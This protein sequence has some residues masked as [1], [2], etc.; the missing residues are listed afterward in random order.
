MKTDRGH[1]RKADNNI[2]TG[3]KS[4]SIL[5]ETERSLS[6]LLLLLFPNAGIEISLQSFLASRS[7]SL[8]CD[9]GTLRGVGMG[10]GVTVPEIDVEDLFRNDPIATDPARD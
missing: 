5:K 6:P 8:D 10:I 2:L 9:N 7:R 4:P 3:N 1:W